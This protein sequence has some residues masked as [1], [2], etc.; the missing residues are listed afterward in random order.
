MTLIDF[1]NIYAHF[2]KIQPG[3]KISYLTGEE[4]EKISNFPIKDPLALEIK[5]TDIQQI[6][7]N[8]G[9]CL[10]VLSGEIKL[11]QVQD[12]IKD[13]I[14]NI[15]NE[16]PN[17]DCIP[18]Y[19]FN[20][21]MAAVVSGLGQ[22]GKNQLVYN[23]DFGFHHSIWTFAIFNPVIN[24][25]KRNPP[26]YSY[27]DMCTDCNECIK[28]CPA[29]ALH[30]DEYPGWLDQEACHE[31]FRFGD[32]PKVASIKYGTNLFL[33][34]PFSEGQLKAVKD[35]ESF[36]QLFGFKNNE[37]IIHKDGYTY[38]VDFSFCAEC[39]NQFPC[40]KIERLYNKDSYE[41]MWKGKEDKSIFA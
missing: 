11:P 12:H 30:G 5:F 29:H 18:L 25:P 32:H 37:G 9:I 7:K 23:K 33:G 13:A 2:L 31:F 3:I 27:M 39:K 26:K 19:N 15:L 4:L 24:L 17:I 8:K 41:I 20:R 34:K 28:N 16:I 40:R 10:I 21:K 6:K 35:N 36:E 1:N 14:L 38:R 22:Y